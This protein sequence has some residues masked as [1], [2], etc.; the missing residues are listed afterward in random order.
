MRK[1]CIKLTLFY[2][3]IFRPFI[4]GI[5]TVIFSLKRVLDHPVQF[6]FN[7]LVTYFTDKVKTEFLI[8]TFNKKYIDLQNP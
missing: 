4:S 1:I 6:S 2:I 5:V 7:T 8:K 3:S